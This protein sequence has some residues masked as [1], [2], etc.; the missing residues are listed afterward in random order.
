MRCIRGNV[1]NVAMMGMLL[2]MLL[3]LLLLLMLL[4]ERQSVGCRV[5]VRV[6]T[7][8]TRQIAS[9]KRMPNTQ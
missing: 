5:R 1:G 2:L 6:C 4:L 3:L 7:G 9:H 8:M